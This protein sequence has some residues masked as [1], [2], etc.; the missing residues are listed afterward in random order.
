MNMKSNHSQNTSE[1]EYGYLRCDESGHWYVVPES[2]IADFD[3]LCDATR[4]AGPYSEEGRELVA[5]FNNRFWKY[6]VG[7]GIYDL[8]VLIE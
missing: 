3:S 2:E 6:A 5:Q 8:R 4:E 1:P 7:G